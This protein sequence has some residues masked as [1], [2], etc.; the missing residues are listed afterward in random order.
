MRETITAPTVS[1]RFLGSPA[2]Y[3]YQFRVPLD[4]QGHECHDLK[5]VA[6]WQ[7]FTEVY[8]IYTPGHY[9]LCVRGP[10][11][12]VGMVFCLAVGAFVMVIGVAASHF[13][14][15]RHEKRQA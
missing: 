7:T 13:W 8:T 14:K 11:W 10:I 15:Y 9:H 12:A 1:E 6:H 3:I 4:A 2:N 5:K